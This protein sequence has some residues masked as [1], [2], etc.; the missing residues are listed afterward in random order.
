MR[1]V[2]SG[3]MPLIRI[4][5]ITINIGVVP[6]STRSVVTEKMRIC[7]AIEYPTLNLSYQQWHADYYHNIV[8]LNQR[9]IYY[10]INNMNLP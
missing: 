7:D 1:A 9:N 6:L 2:A 4:I 3:N 10:M 8:L 5:N